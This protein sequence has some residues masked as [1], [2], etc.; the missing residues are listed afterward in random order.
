MS[1]Q[2]CVSCT[3]ARSAALAALRLLRAMHRSPHRSPHAAGCAPQV[4]TTRFA[5]VHETSQPIM[6][7]QPCVSCT[8]CPLRCASAPVALRAMHRS[9]SQSACSGLRPAGAYD[10]VRPRAWPRLHTHLP[11]QLPERGR[12]S[13]TRRVLHTRRAPLRF[14]T[15][16]SFFFVC[17]RASLVFGSGAACAVAT[18]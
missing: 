18:I 5:L 8:R 9:P 13:R 10:Q 14:A 4:H 6:S 12:V 11:H 7:H 1:H 17:T 2:P 16:N 3:L 15:D